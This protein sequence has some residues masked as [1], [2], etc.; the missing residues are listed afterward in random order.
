M[1]DHA[2][3]EQ[4]VG[5]D[6]DRF[7]I[8]PVL[9]RVF[10]KQP[11]QH[12]GRGQ[13]A[14]GRELARVGLLAQPA[15]L[16]HLKFVLLGRRL[17]AV[18]LFI[19]GVV[20]AFGRLGVFTHRG[21][22]LE[23][24]LDLGA[25]FLERTQL[26]GFDPGQADEVIAEIGLD[27]AGQLAVLQ[28]ED[29]VLE[30]LDHHPAPEEAEV[31]ALLRGSRILR[32]LA[33]QLGELARRLL[34]LGQQRLGACLGLRIVAFRSD[35]DVAGAALLGLL[36]AV[37]AA[38]VPGLHLGV[39]DR[40]L[41]QQ[42]VEREQHVFGLDLLGHFELCGVLVVELLHRRR[43]EL[44]LGRVLL[45]LEAQFAEATLFVLDAQQRFGLHAADQRRFT[46]R[47]QQLLQS[48]V[49]ADVGLELLR[50]HP[51]SAQ[52]RLIALQG[53]LAVLLEGRNA[54]D[55]VGDHRIDDA[56]AVLFGFQQQQPLVDQVVEHGLANLGALHQLGLE[57]RPER[58]A[59]LILAVAQ[60]LL[61]L[62]HG[63]LGFADTGDVVAD[64]AVADVG[65]DAEEGEGQRD[66]TEKNLDDTFV[67]AYG[68]EH[69][70]C[71][72]ALWV[73]WVKKTKRRTCVRLGRDGG[74][75]PPDSKTPGTNQRLAHSVFMAP[76]L[77][78]VPV[79]E[80]R[81]YQK[82]AS[83][84]NPRAMLPGARA[85]SARGTRGSV[86]FLA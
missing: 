11:G 45:G 2:R 43:I 25:H 33:R 44:D 39:A 67:V 49:L 65:I 71:P 50:A 46:D 58:L 26:A 13:R 5:A 35:Q 56:Q 69:D 10:G 16:L 6:F 85:V 22:A 31:A 73:A 75:E 9:D 62:L 34:Q 47:A 80:G 82:P 32:M 51:L 36:E 38:L 12:L 18:R 17:Q 76:Q 54:P 83:P 20:E 27:H 40:D 84:K 15:G 42:A 41:R 8:A 19:N 29:G 52:H 37:L 72:L 74:D 53:E 57:G 1:F 81:V 60:R 64:A 63:D 79:N 28:R 68:V 7:G 66:Q 77:R 86:A 59:H 4:R 21:L 14:E 78:P 3:R 23:F 70:V 55:G 30:G 61:E 48:Q 24:A